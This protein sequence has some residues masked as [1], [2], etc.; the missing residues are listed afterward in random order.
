MKKL[1][2][3]VWLFW[4][5]LLVIV[6]VLA[7]S[8]PFTRNLIF[9]LALVCN[10][11]MFCVTAWV[12]VRT[13][14]S[15]ETLE[16]KILGWPIFHSA[17]V[18]LII[19]VIAATVIMLFAAICPLWLF[20]ILELIIFSVCAL[21]LIIRDVSHTVVTLSE[22]HLNDKTVSFKA[23]RLIA[24]M[25]VSDLSETEVVLAMQKLADEMRFSDPVSTSSSIELE[26]KLGDLFLRIKN[27]IDLQEQLE[28]IREAQQLLHQRNEVVKFTKK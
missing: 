20:I 25:L 24:S 6:T 22:N 4:T 13:V 12:F 2:K 15:V 5:I 27:S 23:L 28:L 21:T 3:H 18:F 11:I 8:I 14:H 1:Y 19:Q 10:A 9:W 16:S 17:V 26:E 7:V